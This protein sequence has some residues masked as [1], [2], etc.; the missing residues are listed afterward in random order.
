[1]GRRQ[2]VSYSTSY[3]HTAPLFLRRSNNINTAA[4]PASPN[5]PPSPSPS[6]LHL[7]YSDS[8]GT[9]KRLP[10]LLAF[11]LP[12]AH[13]L[14]SSPPPDPLTSFILFLSTKTM[15]RHST[16]YSLPYAGPPSPKYS[17]NHST[18]SAFS[19]SANPNEDWTKISDLAERRRI[20]NR[21]AQRNYREFCSLIPIPCDRRPNWSRSS[22]LTGKKA[23][24]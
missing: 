13:L 16:T 18:S 4:R 11:C 5:S 23:R 9:N 12:L 22:F 21:I 2:Y 3:K 1:M 24:R 15:Q 17:S 10:F 20:Q 19:A 8:P 14:L 7:P 6:P